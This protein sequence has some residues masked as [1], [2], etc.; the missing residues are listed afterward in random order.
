MKTPA[1]SLC[2]ILAAATL[3][4]CAT[5]SPRARIENRLVELG[6]APGK[7]DCMAAELDDRLSRDDL[8]AVA[9]F[10]GQLNKADSA[11][12]VLDALIGIDNARAAAAIGAAGVACAFE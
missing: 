12:G 7:A 6:F 3:A 11:G 4:S 8:N 5:I 1:K 9:D 2:L 10:V